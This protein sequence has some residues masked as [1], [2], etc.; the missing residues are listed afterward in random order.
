MTISMIIGIVYYATSKWGILLEND[1]YQMRCN[2][3][4]EEN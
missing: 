2:E 4:A 1:S 3:N